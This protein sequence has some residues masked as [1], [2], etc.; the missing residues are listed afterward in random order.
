VKK[1]I[2]LDSKADLLVYGMGEK[3]ALE[4]LARLRNGEKISE[5][6]D[7][8]GTVWKAGA[9]S[10]GSLPKNSVELPSWEEAAADK[11][12]FALM[13]K[14]IYENL[15]PFC[16][17][18]LV[19]KADGRAVAANPP[20]LPLSTEEIDAVYSLPFKR[21]PHPSYKKP[22]PAYET[23]R[24]SIIIH[25]GCFG[26]CTFCSLGYH[27]GKF[28]QSRSPASVKK[29]AEKL[30]R[31]NGGGTVISDLG[32]PSAN[33]YALCGRELSLCEKCR[34]TSCL[35]PGVCQNLETSHKKLLEL[36]RETGKVKGV[37]K[38]FIASG[39][40]MDLA[41][42]DAEYISEIASS[43]TGGYLKVAPEHTEKTALEIMN[44]PC[45]EI[46][47]A[48][49]KEFSKSSAKA[50]KEQYLIP[51][52]ISA[53]P[54]TTL[55]DAVNMAVFLKK[56]DYRPLQINDFL[57]APGEY[58]TAIYYSELDPATLRKIHVPRKEGERKLHRALLQYFKPENVPLIAKALR[59]A[60]RSD[61]LA[62]LTRPYRGKRPGRS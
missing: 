56:H 4:I 30:V 33:M 50:G 54:G 1:P 21:K 57:P 26:G 27:Q 22:V 29:E 44:K 25:R 35:Y 16:A 60:G 34:R 15:N 47:L 18:P 41:L 40:R 12:K 36:M 42:K 6:R 58:A 28:I 20:S 61:L 7:V 19:Q 46:F 17:G 23:V 55:A 5:I 31:E 24:N 38:I 2:L 62:W 48:F 9:A 53:Y 3:S 13:T 51:Y 52:F 43:H 39:I 49:E 59:L 32:A 10:L 11:L 14:L 37:K 45:P 8:R